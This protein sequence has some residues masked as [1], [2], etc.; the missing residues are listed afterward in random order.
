MFKAFLDRACVR[1]RLD[2]LKAFAGL[3]W[4]RIAAPGRRGRHRTD[5]CGTFNGRHR[6][7]APTTVNRPMVDMT[8][9]MWYVRARF[10]AVRGDLRTAET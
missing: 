3:L 7:L 4:R 5:A 8:C 9:D 1:S 10:V 2:P 6:K